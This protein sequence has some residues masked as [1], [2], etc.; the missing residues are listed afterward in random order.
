MA[1]VSEGSE[2]TL[3]KVLGR[4]REKG[5]ALKKQNVSRSQVFWFGECREWEC[6]ENRCEAAA[7]YVC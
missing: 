4:G 5:E 7:E 3:K 1:C 6:I 2:K